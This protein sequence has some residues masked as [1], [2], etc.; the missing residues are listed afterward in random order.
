MIVAAQNAIRMR[1]GL[2]MLDNLISYTVT[3]VVVGLV[4][5]I[6]SRVGRVRAELRFAISMFAG[7]TS[8]FIIK[9]ALAV[10]FN[11]KAIV[12]TICEHIAD[13]FACAAISGIVFWLYEWFGAL[14]TKSAGRA[15]RPSERP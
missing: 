7:F 6:G 4:S 12:P 15:G 2:A 8:G 13:A 3:G 14:G 1:K 9:E 5:W 11:W 10:G